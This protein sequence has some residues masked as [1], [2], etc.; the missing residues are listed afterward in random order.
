M[1][2]TSKFSVGIVILLIFLFGNFEVASFALRRHSDINKAQI[3]VG[4]A[5]Y[6][7]TIGG[8]LE[9]LLIQF[10]GSPLKSRNHLSQFTISLWLKIPGKETQ[11]KEK[12]LFDK[13]S[14]TGDDN[15]YRFS[16]IDDITRNIRQLKIS[17]GQNGVI[18]TNSRISVP[19]QEWTFSWIMDLGSLSSC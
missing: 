19:S 1:T 8:A 18:D 10:E 3:V 12:I 4:R 17:L 5:G 16:I 14:I 2:I 15:E 11:I 9:G 7:V 13:S 6:A